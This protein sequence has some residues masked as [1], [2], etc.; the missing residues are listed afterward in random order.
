[1]QFS[2]RRAAGGIIAVPHYYHHVRYYSVGRALDG[3]PQLK[4]NFFPA[5][6]WLHR[7]KRAP[8]SGSQADGCQVE[9]F[10]PGAEASLLCD[11]DP[12]FFAVAMSR[13]GLRCTNGK[14]KCYFIFSFW[15]FRVFSVLYA[16]GPAPVSICSPSHD[17]FELEGLHLV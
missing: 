11:P 13:T 2:A 1:V 8:L 5:A 9:S 4:S 3:E 15:C 14:G 17:V 7:T 16:P 10:I 6:M 12:F